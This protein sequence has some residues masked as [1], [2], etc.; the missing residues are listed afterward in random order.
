MAPPTHVNFKNQFFQN[1]SDNLKRVELVKAIFWRKYHENTGKDFYLQAVVPEE[2]MKNLIRSLHED[3]MQGHWGSKNMLYHLRQRYYCPNLVRQST[4]H[5]NKCQTC[6]RSKPLA[7][8]HLRPPLQKN[9]YPNNGPEHLLEIDSGGPLPPS[10]GFRSILIAVA[11]FS[12]YRIAILMRRPDAQSAVKG[13]KSIFTTHAYV[14]NNILLDKGTT[15]T[16]EA[17][18]R[19]VKQAGISNRHA[20]TK[21]A[22]KIG[23][24]DPFHQKL[25]TFLMK[26][27][28]TDQTQWNQYVNIAKTVHKT[29]YHASLKCAAEEISHGRT[30]HSALDLTIAN[31]L[32][33]TNQSTDLSKMLDEFKERYKQNVRNI[34]TGRTNILIR[35][36][37]RIPTKWW[38]YYPIVTTSFERNGLTKHNASEGCNCDILYR[39]TR[40]KTLRYIKRTCS[41][42][43]M[44]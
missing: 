37:G 1:L 34:V 31:P 16:A 20:F 13:L 21:Q 40:L 9:Y 14:P 28:S 44:R 27:I 30:T 10:D 38:E 7:K 3:I 4:S 33:A 11:V 18:K 29:S 25:D 23:I 2:N 17:V 12:R 6:I 19:T 36:T 15:F 5:N 41:A 35:S 42:T 22:Q 8:Q 39:K 32:R 26:N 24:I 43:R